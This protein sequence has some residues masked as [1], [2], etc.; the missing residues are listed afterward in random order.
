MA[1]K[2]AMA[3]KNLIT[4]VA[5]ILFAKHALAEQTQLTIELKAPKSTLTSDTIHV[6]GDFNNWALSGSEAYQLAFKNGVFT[7][8]I[9]IKDQNTFFTFVKN[10]SWQSMPANKYGKTQ[11]T[12][13]YQRTDNQT[14]L[15]V[16][17]S[18]WK[19]DE[20]IAKAQS[21]LTGHFAHHKDFVMPELSRIGDISVYLPRSYKANT[22]QRYPVLYMLDG[23]NVFDEATSYSSEWAID[24]MLE[25]LTASGQMQEII[26]VS[27]P[28]SSDRW[29][30]YNP[31]DFKGND[32]K[33]ISGKGHDTIRFISQTLKPFIDTNYRSQ[34]S[35]NAT[36]L[37][38]SSLGGLMA[39]YAGLEHS[40]IFGFVGVFSPAL[41]IENMAGSNVLFEAI[42]KHK[43]NNFAKIYMDIGKM[44]YGNYQQIER[45]YQQL[46]NLGIS[47]KHIKLVKDDL[48]RHCEVDWSKRF[49]NA[50]Q[51]LLNGG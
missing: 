42:N 12:Y 6:V 2:N 48:G 26:I 9:P 14:T 32:G 50:I 33:K 27:V 22:E 24:E 43:G 30:E 41:A 18:N 25:K 28:N 35:A 13:F 39:L 4:F 7:T 37:A 19:D 8:Q 1:R 45:L 47:S 46:L 36:G 20:V 40:K 23:Q 3:Y 5:L 21:S 16:S 51:W 17:F 38:G 44:E 15:D 10:K 31:W 34:K 11:C 29:Q 49:P